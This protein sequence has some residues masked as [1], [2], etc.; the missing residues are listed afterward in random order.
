MQK[1]FFLI[2]YMFID[3][4]SKFQ[5][6]KPNFC[7]YNLDIYTKDYR[8]LRFRFQFSTG[9]D[10]ISQSLYPFYLPKFREIYAMQFFH[11][12]NSLEK[13]NGGWSLYDIRREYKRQGIEEDNKFVRF[14]DNNA[15]RICS[16]YPALLL[17]P[18]CLHL[19][20]IY[21]IFPQ[22]ILFMQIRIFINFFM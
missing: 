22:V 12:L 4:I 14:V 17:V 10:K 16:T 2:P 1:S 5:D 8:E 18:V 9:P 19:L 11:F 15:G 13:E 21:I 6:K 20:C 3:K 7:H